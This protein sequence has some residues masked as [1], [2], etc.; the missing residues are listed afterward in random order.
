MSGIVMGR[1]RDTPAVREIGVDTDG[2]MR[3]GT[4]TKSFGK[5]A[6]NSG[7]DIGDVDVTSIAA[8]ETHVGEVGGKMLF[9]STNFTRPANTTAYTAK[10]ALAN[11]TSA[12]TVL[13][14]ANAV[15]VSG[16]TG[17]VVSARINTSQ[18]ICVARFRLHLFRTTPTAINDNAAYTLLDANFAVRLGYIDF[19]AMQTEG[20]GSTA[21]NSQNATV[22]LPIVCGAT[23]LFGLLESLDAFTPASAQT[24]KVEL[25]VEAN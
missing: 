13:S 23:T 17:Y 12:P 11:S 3:L 9:A 25:V 2:D 6:A 21:A 20:T 5:L 22:R 24:F 10:D 19:P 7:V 4:S 14:F 16:G 15:R 18:T 1:D 8:G